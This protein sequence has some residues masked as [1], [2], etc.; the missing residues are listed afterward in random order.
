MKSHTTCILTAIA[1]LGASAY[2][3]A[4]LTSDVSQPRQMA[5]QK[6]A[7][8]Q[9]MQTAPQTQSV[10]TTQPTSPPAQGVPAAQPTTAPTQRT[11]PQRTVA[12]TWD[13]GCALDHFAPGQRVARQIRFAMPI[14]QSDLLGVLPEPAV[15]HMDQ[16]GVQ[17]G[18][19]FACSAFGPGHLCYNWH[20]GNDFSLG[21]S[22]LQMGRVRAR[23]AASG[24]VIAADD[25]HFDGCLVN[26]DVP[27]LADEDPDNNIICPDPNH[28]ESV[29]LTDANVVSVCHA[30]GTITRYYHLMRDS[31]PPNVAVGTPIACGATVGLVGSSGRSS[32][33]HLHFDVLVPASRATA[34][35]VRTKE[36]AD[37]TYVYVDPFSTSAAASLWTQ[38]E[39]N[40]GPTFGG[41][42]GTPAFAHPSGH[43]TT[44]ACPHLVPP[45]ANDA[46]PVLACTHT[47][48]AN[49]DPLMAPCLHRKHVSDDGLPC[50]HIEHPAGHQVVV[51][52]QPQ[53]GACVHPQHPSGHA[54]QVP[55]THTRVPQHPAGHPGPTAPCTHLVV[56]AGPLSD[57]FSLP[58]QQ[59]DI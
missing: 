39:W 51:L 34:A 46:G 4:P 38:Q 5:T 28:P 48:H 47:A 23:A 15:I 52:G 31:I 45:H 33:P 26:P 35:N 43:A 16:D 13:F 3:A 44:L 55:C 25:A 56:R 19:L 1:V 58:G 18:D 9:P 49:G 30:D 40:Y 2:A 50:T 11:M 6:Q 53:F 42:G 8:P 41:V 20:E 32:G 24:V 7:A 59:C 54:T 36:I 27:A 57:T 14:P 12:S 37:R 17:Q 22:F 21:G 10:P 29:A